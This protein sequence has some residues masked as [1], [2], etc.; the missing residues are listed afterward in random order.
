M[1]IKS[2][3]FSHWQMKLVCILLAFGLWF[4]VANEGFQTIEVAEGVPVEVN[5]LS[6]DLAV[7]EDLGEVTISV[8]PSASNLSSQLSADTFDAYID[9]EGLSK[10]TYDLPIRVVAFDASVQVLRVEPGS[11]K[12]T[13]DDK[14]KKSFSVIPEVIGTPGEGYKAGDPELS[15]ESVMIGGAESIVGTVRSVVA[16]I[17]VGG[18]LA[19]VQKTVELKA[20]NASGDVVQSI[21][22]DPKTIEVR[23]PISQEADVKTVGIK[24]ITEGEL[25]P[26]YFVEGIQSDPSTISIKGERDILSEISYINTEPINLS[27]VTESTEK[28]VGL[29]IPE[30]AES[31]STDEVVVN[32]EI[33]GSEVTESV[34]GI[35]EFR[36]LADGSSLGNFSPAKATVTVAGTEEAIAAL[37]E[38]DVRVIVDLAGKGPGTY[39][40]PLSVNSVSVSDNVSATNLISSSIEITIN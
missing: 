7:V 28:I 37:T 30:G 27:S 31:E 5:N 14:I 12:V 19:D 1:N 29:D 21:Y 26:G 8:R 24:V 10:G 13:L 2:I 18:E 34:S 16:D 32:I 23:V 40:V 39:T 38:N 36:N 15:T 6:D 4:Y 3:L 11:V 9:T 33:T 17:E 35:F 22:I 25:K 20:L